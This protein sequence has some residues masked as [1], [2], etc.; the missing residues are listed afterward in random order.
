M[1][2]KNSQEYLEQEQYIS[3]THFFHPAADRHFAYILPMPP[4]PN[5]TTRT[6]GRSRGAA[7][8]KEVSGTMRGKEVGGGARKSTLRAELSRGRDM[9][10]PSRVASTQPRDTSPEESSSGEETAG[11][12]DY[13]EKQES[14]VQRSASRAS[15]VELEDEFEEGKKGV[16]TEEEDD[17]EWVDEDEDD[18]QELLD[19]EFH[20]TYVMNPEKRRK[21]W[22]Q[23]WDELVRAVCRLIVEFLG[24]L[25]TLRI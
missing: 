12:H 5:G 4:I 6:R 2:R 3:T 21:R 22:D 16:L 19:L 17:G 18:E 9:E 14:I 10:P 13:H 7:K 11:E 25:L 8:E 1:Q 20:P 23:R 24:D 15:R